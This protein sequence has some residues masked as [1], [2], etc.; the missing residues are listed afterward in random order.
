M[1]PAELKE[2]AIEKHSKYDQEF[3]ALEDYV[4][5]YPDFKVVFYFPG[6]SIVFQL[7]KYKH[8]LAK[9]YSQILF[10]LCVLLHFKQGQSL[11]GKIN[12][13][14]QKSELLSTKEGD[15]I[16][17]AAFSNFYINL[18][19]IDLSIPPSNCSVVSSIDQPPTTAHHM[20]YQTP[21]RDTNEELQGVSSEDF[22]TILNSPKYEPSKSAD[23][24][25]SAEK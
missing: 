18:E 24:G 11:S 21:A 22:P 19:T 23:G 15:D 5:L 6:S 13:S 16:L 3:C 14:P 2:S 20:I 1:Q 17:F 9:P 10:Y 8:G 25:G 4:L 12:L 7:D